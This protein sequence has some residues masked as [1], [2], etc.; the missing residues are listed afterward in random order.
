MN[1][2][3]RLRQTKLLTTLPLLLWIAVGELI[4]YG[5]AY[6]T[7]PLFLCMVSFFLAKQRREAAGGIVIGIVTGEGIC[8]VMK[9]L[10]LPAAA[11]RLGTFPAQ[12]I[13]VLVFVLAIA[14]LEPIFPLCMNS[15]TFLAFL[16]AALAVPFSPGLWMCISFFGG[17]ICIAGCLLIQRLAAAGSP[18]EERCEQ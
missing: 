12:L 1:V 16:V 8:W 15:H 9:S 13:F 4:C 3:Q 17:S 18:G 7:W 2:I 5:L 10:W 14:Y 6:P 11:D